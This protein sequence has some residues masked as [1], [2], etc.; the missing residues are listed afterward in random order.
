MTK[1]GG[2]R[3]DDGHTAENPG[4]AFFLNL[5]F[6]L[7]EI[8]GGFY[9]NSVAILADAVHDTGDSV[10]LGVSWWFQR[11]SRKESDATFTYGYRRF[12]AL[13]ALITGIVL[14]AGV[15]FILW[16]TVP[17]VLNPEPVNAPIMIVF[18]VLGV[19]V[20][21]AAALKLR[22]GSSLNESVVSWHLLEDVLGWLA[23]LLGSVAT[24]IRSVP[25]LDPLL[26]IGVSLFVLWN[27][28]GK[29]RRVLK[30]FLQEAPASFSRE[31]FERDVSALP[32]FQSVHHA[33]AWSIDGDNH[34][35]SAHVVMAR[36]TERQKIVESK[37]RIV[38]MIADQP[39]E[40]TTIEVELE[41]EPCSA[42]PEQAD[43]RAHRQS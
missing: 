35:L 18:A 20:N 7:I 31:T 42:W 19:L 33:H 14:L 10:S 22:G 24:T 16:R 41:G 11:L 39:F 40:H 43:S 13:G 28:V 4:F 25:I 9:T 3:S 2:R 30:V 15:A 32:G 36:N 8:A 38:A 23:V 29:L 6:T 5:G 17:R 12:S 37:Q 21:G 27:V 26:S 34:V 1:A